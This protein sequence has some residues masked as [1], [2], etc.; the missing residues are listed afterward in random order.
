M[1]KV[2]IIMPIYNSEKYI[3]DAVLSVLNQTYKNFELI[4]VDDGSTDSSLEIIKQLEIQDKRIKA[5]YK[6]NGGVSSARNYGLKKSTGTYVA[7]IDN[8]DEYLPNLLEE[9]IRLIEKYQA[10]MIKFQKIKLYIEEE[11]N[12]CLPEN[13]HKNIEVYEKEEIW[14]NFD[15]INKFGGT[16]W[17]ILYKKK[18]LEENQ[19]Y[20]KEESKNEIEDHHFNLDCYKHLNKIVCNFKYYY[21]WKVRV[22]HSTTGHFIKERFENIKKEGNNLYLFLK[23]K[24]IDKLNPHFWAKIK[25]SY[26]INIL[27]VMN[28]KKSGFHNKKIFKKYLKELKKLELFSRK[29][30][31][32]D[33]VYLLKND[34]VFRTIA[35]IIFDM[36][37][38]SLLYILSRF[39]LK[40]EVKN[41]NRRF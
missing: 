41:K 10:D 23:T 15:K 8:D 28:Y 13:K 11:T 38:L 14:K 31:V 16:I 25:V 19:I 12:Y 4:L 40:R 6:E 39:K 5:Y 33:Y 32:K 1:E 18:F 36:N 37:W 26:L 2:S 30:V 35:C 29:C 3:K 27:L 9:N 17:N 21:I 7:F 24:N 20:F 34:T 22:N